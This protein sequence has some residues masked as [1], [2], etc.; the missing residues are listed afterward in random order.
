MVTI[1][2]NNTEA[3][4]IGISDKKI[5]NELDLQLSYQIPGYQFMNNS[6]GWDGRYR[7][8]KKS[9]YFPIGLRGMVELILTKRKVLYQIID[10]RPNI[11][12]NPIPMRV[13]TKY[14]LRDYQ[15]DAFQAAIKAEGGILQASV[16]AGKTLIISAILAHYNC[17][18]VVYVIGTDLLYQMKKTIEDAY[19]IEC[20]V[21]G[22]GICDI[23]KV[24]VATLWSCGSAYGQKIEIDDNDANIDKAAKNK[25]L[26]K[27]A[28][29]KMVEGAELIF[30]DE[31]QYCGGKT[32]MWLH[33]QSV[34]AKYRFLLSGTPW[35]N[36][37]NENI[38][39]EAIGGPKFYQIT[40]SDLIR[41]EWLVPPE[42][43]FVEMPSLKAAGTN[44]QEVYQ[45][46]IVNNFERNAK[47]V[48]ICK[49]LVAAGRKVLI[50]VVR[51][52]H[53]KEIYSLLEDE[54]MRVAMLDGKNSSE[55]R[56]KVI[57]SINN[58]LIDVTVAS[59]IFD[60]GIDVP[61]LDSLVL[62]GSGKS[63]SRALQRIGRVIRTGPA[64]KKDAIVI[65]FLDNCKY[66]KEHS[67][68][69]FE[70]YKT[71]PEFKIKLPNGKTKI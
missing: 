58:N 6:T 33:Q 70:I 71:E 69:R 27:A 62:A 66:L 52:E 19:S 37:S 34:S 7:L 14:A 49:K 67:K 59:K 9:G 20:G 13:G 60:Q 42:I 25:N 47:I 44:Y 3:R 61:A 36:A 68:S 8:F 30:F 63:S 23:K 55:E 2:L 15:T 21:V 43:H 17:K 16:G 12:P 22:D 4:L 50:L 65:D 28:I 53:G 24:T 48:S 41:K 1:E 31:A 57:E 45:N 54:N 35:R 40:S 39:L 10:S 56:M 32:A 51:I 5:L 64:D 46:Y 38:L 18:T 26:D 29:R 11:I